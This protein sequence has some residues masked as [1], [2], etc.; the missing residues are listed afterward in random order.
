V[1]VNGSRNGNAVTG[2]GFLERKNHRTYQDT[3][4]LLKNVGHMVQ[5]NLQKMYP[6]DASK[7]WIDKWVIGR[8][9]QTEGV[10]PKKVCDTLFRPIRA[11]I[12]RGGKAWRSLILVS[13][14]NALSTTYMDCSRYIAMSELLHVG[15]LVIDD[16]QDESTVRRGGKCVHMEFGVAHA[17]NSGTGC[18][19]MAPIL[20]GVD[21]LPNDQQLRMYQL[22]FDAMRAGHAGQGLDMEGLDYLMPAVVENGDTRA[23]LAALRAIHI[24]KTG[25]AAGTMCRMACVLTNASEVQ[26]NALEHFG[27]QIG[28]AFQIVDDALNLKGFEGDLKEVGED[29]R[30]G[31]ITYPVIKALGRVDRADREY[32]WEILQE[33]TSDRGKIKSV[34][35]KLNAVHAIDDC[36]AE[37]RE[38]VESAWKSVDPV[39]PD[40]LP[41]IMMRT[42]CLYLTERTY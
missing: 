36:M 35:D 2:I 27:C 3:K 31:K 18:Y 32:I 26:S 37:A 12:D 29:I 1:H 20:S 21:D 17:I 10:D 22:Y 15:S 40:S 7:E 25:G 42:F 6:L 16:I 9:A 19:F 33:K 14:V 5:T 38:I 13:C 11:L 28:L 8:H 34:I 39:I 24:Y 4:G 23:I 30:D 41:K